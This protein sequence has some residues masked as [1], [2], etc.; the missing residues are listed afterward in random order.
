M[1]VEQNNTQNN[2]NQPLLSFIITTFNLPLQYLEECIKSITVLSL[3][4]A[5]REII[6]IDDGTEVSQINSLLDSRDDII[7]VR[8]SNKGISMA[9]NLGIKIS[10]GKYIQFV[11]GDDLILEAPYEHCLDVVRFHDPDMVIFNETSKMKVETP[12]ELYGP[13][14]GNVY[15]SNNNMRSPS[16][17]YIFKREILGTLQ[18]TPK[19]YH[20]DEEF[21]PQLII[22]AH[23]LYSTNANAYFYRQHADSRNNDNAHRE[24]RL[25]DIE[26]ILFHLKQL[27]EN[28]PTDDALAMER[29]IDQLTMDYLYNTIRLTHS[30]KQLS[31]AIEHL[32]SQGLYPLPNKKYTKKYTL[33][34]KA[35]SSHIGRTVMICMIK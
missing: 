1:P 32:K 28:M 33:F 35:I 17:G 14:M 29:R 3:R 5:E 26:R 22:K 23:N 31:T 34:R 21:T 19:S 7:Y 11:D 6:L 2:E 18:F 25:K 30:H 9:R 20:E 10:S 12:F 24:D 16:W 8:Q 15:M 13:I 27:S 4:P